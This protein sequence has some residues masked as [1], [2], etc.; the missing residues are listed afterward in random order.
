MAAFFV[1]LDGHYGIYIGSVGETELPR[2]YSAIK[3]A[4]PH[5]YCKKTGGEGCVNAQYMLLNALTMLKI[6]II[7]LPTFPDAIKQKQIAAVSFVGGVSLPTANAWT[8][9]LLN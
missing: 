3:K 6:S 9:R 7:K 5:C 2:R 8:G 4:L 1:S